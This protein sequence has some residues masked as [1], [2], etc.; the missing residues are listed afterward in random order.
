MESKKPIQS[1]KKMKLFQTVHKNLA[2]LKF[3]SNQSDSFFPLIRQ[4]WSCFL[5]SFLIITSFSM[6]L[7][8]VATTAKESMDT[9]FLIS[10]SIV[11]VVSFTS[12]VLKTPK[13]YS[14]LNNCEDATYKS[15]YEKRLID[16][17]NWAKKS[18]KF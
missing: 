2:I 8:H 5:K 15:E 11:V 17:L 9:L 6:Y 14:F 10:T 4:H 16:S 12:I 3:I 7:A 18:N 13:L 1:P